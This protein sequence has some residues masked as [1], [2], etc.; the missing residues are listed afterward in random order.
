MKKYCPETIIIILKDNCFQGSGYGDIVSD[1]YKDT[2][3][4]AILM[5]GYI[6]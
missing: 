1:P 6:L 4:P 3:G 5:L 2:A